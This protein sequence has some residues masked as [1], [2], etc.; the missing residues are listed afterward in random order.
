VERSL[1]EYAAIYR[2]WLLVLKGRLQQQAVDLPEELFGEGEDEEL[3]RFALCYH[4]LQVGE[5]DGEAGG[6]KSHQLLHAL[7]VVG[8]GVT[9]QRA[10]CSHT[11]T[12][13]GH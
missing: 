9:E 2:E 8:V 7:V 5:G 12:G 4:I 6:R 3:M 10:S 11:C 13:A 1:T